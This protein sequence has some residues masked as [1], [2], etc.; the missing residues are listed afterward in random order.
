MEELAG[1]WFQVGFHFGEATEA[2]L[3]PVPL[4]KAGPGLRRVRPSWSFAGIVRAGGSTPVL[5]Q[6]GVRAVLPQDCLDVL[7]SETHVLVLREAALEGWP[8]EGLALILDGKPAWRCELLP[9]D[10]ATADLPLV[11]GGHGQLG[12][13]DLESRTEPQLVEAL[14][15]VPL[16]DVAA[17]GWHSA[18]ISEIGDLYIWGWN[19]SGQ[20]ALPSKSLA[21]SK[22][23]TAEA[24]QGDKKLSLA[25]PEE[26]Q[27]PHKATFISIQAFPA[28]LDMPDG[29]DVQ[30][31][32]CG[33]RHTAA[34]TLSAGAQPVT[35]F[36]VFQA[37]E[38][39][40]PGAG[41]NTANWGTGTL[42]A[43][44]SHGECAALWTGVL[45][46]WMLYVDHGP[47]IYILC[48]DETQEE[49]LQQAR[50]LCVAVT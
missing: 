46:W 34:V 48:H 21:E 13:G 36:L 28:L 22:A 31:V 15:G 35:P 41:V 3:A 12:H 29:A 2:G 8:V 24:N 6:G 26:A 5:L 18:S 42:P 16:V 47:P 30:K 45:V 9:E 14:Q 1:G 44:M 20:L 33:S 19:E 25:Q 50:N 32:S 27:G 38:I 10:A 17:G 40:T 4:D 23:T 43:L 49:Q 7:P 11:P 39:S 37:P